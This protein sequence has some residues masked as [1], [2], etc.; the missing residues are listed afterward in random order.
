MKHQHYPEGDTED[1]DDFPVRGEAYDGEDGQGRPFSL[2]EKIF[3]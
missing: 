2:F 1:T 3:P